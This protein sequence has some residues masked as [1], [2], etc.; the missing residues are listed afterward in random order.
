MRKT[1]L[2]ILAV[3][4]V[5]GAASFTACDLLRKDK[6]KPAKQA[7]VPQASDYV[8]MSAMRA[9]LETFGRDSYEWYVA[10]V[11][12]GGSGKKLAE[13]SRAVL[14]ERIGFL[15]DQY[16]RILEDSDTL[17]VTYQLSDL[18]DGVLTIT[19]T[20]DHAFFAKGP[21]MTGR[22]D[23]NSG[24]MLIEESPAYRSAK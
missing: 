16:S 21:L 15:N 17:R 3:V 14:A 7:P 6:D 1:I 22:L 24:E 12:Q 10:P 4:I 23:L 5:T 2:L 8:S 9:N 11:S 20:P 18:V 13:G 19:A